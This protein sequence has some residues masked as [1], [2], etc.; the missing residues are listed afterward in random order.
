M[1]T[2]ILMR[3]ILSNNIPNSVTMHK[4]IVKA[5]AGAF[6]AD[7]VI[8]NEEAYI[9]KFAFHSFGATNI[10][11]RNKVANK[12]IWANTTSVNGIA[13]SRGSNTDDESITIAKFENNYR[14][15]VFYKLMLWSKSITNT[16]HINMLRNLI[17]NGGIID[18][19]DSIFDQTSNE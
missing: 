16:Y 12:I 8:N 13:V 15:M 1:Y 19:N 9:N 17:N 6:T 2:Y 4:G 7:Y 10:I 3:Q 14:R 5:Y 18:L 11:Y